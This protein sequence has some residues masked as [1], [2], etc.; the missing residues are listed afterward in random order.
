MQPSDLLS[1]FVLLFLGAPFAAA[2]L[3]FTGSEAVRRISRTIL[4]WAWLANGAAVIACLWYG[5]VKP[6][7]GIGNQ[8]LWLVA[9]PIALF[10]IIWFGLW[11]AA[12]RHEY[13]R[14]LPPA[15]RKVEEVFDIDRGLE[16][17]RKNLAQSQ[18][19]LDSWTI[20]GEERDRLEE[21]VGLLKLTIANLERERAKRS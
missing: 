9:I 1:V 21:N 11:R 6:S 7:S 10:A 12:R 8:V 15:E 17:A 20:S 3:A 14:S 5:S 19:R 4:F 13:V 16:A 18:R 2:I